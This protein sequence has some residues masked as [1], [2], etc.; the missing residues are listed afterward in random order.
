VDDS[1]EARSARWNVRLAGPDDFPHVVDFNRR[2]ARETEGKDLDP[3]TLERGVRRALA[4]PERLRYWVAEARDEVIGQAA[5][6]GEWSDW[7][8]GWIW[9][10]QSVYVR[11]TFRG[12]GVLKALLAAIRRAA[13]MRGDVVG[14]R[15]YVER[16]NM[17][18]Q[19]VY[20]ALGFHPAGYLVFE[21]DL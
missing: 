3:Q 19:Q 20:Q 9:W 1:P 21:A 11:E 6:T 8:A 16:E 14:L 13:A 4:D 17:S 18:A 2:L 12:Q 15:L 10:L 7:R 5:V